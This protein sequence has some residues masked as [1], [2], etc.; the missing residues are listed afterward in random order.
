MLKVILRS[1]FCKHKYCKSEKKSCLQG[2]E[3]RIES[4]VLTC[5]IYTTEALRRSLDSINKVTKLTF[6]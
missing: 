6:K 3:M 2:I 4:Q 5:W 1:S